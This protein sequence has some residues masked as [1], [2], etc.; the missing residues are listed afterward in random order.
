MARS[1]MCHTL[2]WGDNT[3]N[4][5]LYLSGVIS[6]PEATCATLSYGGIIHIIQSYRIYIYVYRI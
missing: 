5:E 4:T 6:W 1:Y 3:Y 2:L